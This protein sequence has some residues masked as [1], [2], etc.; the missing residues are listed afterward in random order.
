RAVAHERRT[1]DPRNRHRHIGEPEIR[2]AAVPL[3]R[4]GGNAA[5]GRD[6]RKLALKRLLRGEYDAQRHALPRRDRRGQD[7]ELSRIVASAR[8]NRGARI[9]SRESESKKCRGEQQRCCRSRNKP[10]CQKQS[11][12]RLPSPQPNNTII[13]ALAESWRLS[14]ISTQKWRRG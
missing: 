1:P 2:W 4:F 6:Q 8:W 9:R 12:P 3:A 7:R 14:R 5:V 11:S 10:A 13:K